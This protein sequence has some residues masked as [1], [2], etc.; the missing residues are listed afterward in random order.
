MSP[1]SQLE[2]AYRVARER[3][4]GDAGVCG[5]DIGFLPDKG[6]GPRVGVRVHR[7]DGSFRVPPGRASLRAGKAI[8][9]AFRARY[10]ASGCYAT[11]GDQRGARVS[12]LQPGIC[13]GRRGTPEATGTLGAIVYDRSGRPGILSNWHVLAGNAQAKDKDAIVQ[14]GELCQDPNSRVVARLD[15]GRSF[16][17]VAGDAAVAFLEKGLHW[18]REP[19]GSSVLL[20]GVRR[21]RLGDELEKSGS[22]T[23]ITRGRVDGVGRYFIVLE[24][25]RVAI[26]GFR[27]VPRD[28]GEVIA[29]GG[30]SG[31]LWYDPTTSLG[32]GLHFGRDASGTGAVLACHL[33]TVLSK[34]RVSLTPPVSRRGAR[35]SRRWGFKAPGVQGAGSRIVR[36][37][38]N[39]A[40]VRGDHHS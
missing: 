8:P 36:R 40:R 5:I 1:R 26:D 31:S 13:V 10:G 16:R 39:G 18:K 38:N 25:E 6:G 34:L 29:Y 14:P 33:P 32:V 28:E 23:A 35:R 37:G 22:K 24:S 2:V 30:D 27:L 12:V 3:Y 19:L 11:D 17:G 7:L 15:L 4:G 21:A 9:F 20:A